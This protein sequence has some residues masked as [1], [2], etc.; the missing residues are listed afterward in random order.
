MISFIRRR[1]SMLGATAIGAG[2]FVLGT[3][4]ADPISRMQ[5][6]RIAFEVSIPALL[7]TIFILACVLIAINQCKAR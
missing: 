4:C 7:V 5:L 6:N 3:I 1:F 2:A